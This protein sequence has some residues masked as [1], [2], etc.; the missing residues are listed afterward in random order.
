MTEKNQAFEVSGT[1]LAGGQ[2]AKFS[3]TV[4]APSEKRASDKVL[5]LIGSHHR[6][7]RHKI[8]ITKTARAKEESR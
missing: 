8:K 3:K 1:F 5:A 2:E 4:S 7:P 6:V